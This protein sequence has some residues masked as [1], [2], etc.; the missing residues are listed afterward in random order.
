M[1][2]VGD[3]AVLVIPAMLMTGLVLV[4][5]GIE[6]RGAG[7]PVATVGRALPD[8]AT[9]AGVCGVRPAC[10]RS[11]RRVGTG[12]RADPVGVGPARPGSVWPS[13]G[14]P[15]GCRW[16]RCG[17]R[18]RRRLVELREIWPDAIDNLALGVRAGLSLPE[19]VA[20]LAERGPEALRSPFGR[21]A[22]DYHATGRFGSALDRLKEELAD[23]SAD[24]VIEALRLA[25]RSAAS[26]AGCCAPCR[27]SSVTTS[28]AQGAGGAA[29]LGRGRG[30]H[31][32]RHTVGGPVAARH[33]A[34]SRRRLRAPAAPSSC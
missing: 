30:P 10:G 3:L 15:G 25:R 8:W 14:W 2:G 6:G 29:D 1:S 23:P 12:R 17:A 24:R 28:G 9:Q 18:R 34:R 32:L 4:G 31:G 20:G 11:V 16:A 21:F 33:Q 27:A 26:S 22:D 5:L 7:C 13:P 19:A